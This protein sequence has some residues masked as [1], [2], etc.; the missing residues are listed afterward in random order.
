MAIN[1]TRLGQS[2]AFA[3]GIRAAAGELIVLI[4]ADLQNDPDDLPVL[5]GRLRSSGADMVQGDRRT[6]RADGLVR[7]VSSAAGRLARRWL[8]GD[9]I[10]DTGCSLRIL[11]REV[12][13]RLPL[14]Y[15][16]MHRFIPITCRQLGYTV[17][18]H[19]V[20]HRP[21]QAGDSKYGILNR[22]IPGL[23][24]CFAVRWMHKR[25]RPIEYEELA[26]G[27]KPKAAGKE[28]SS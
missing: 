17:V 4:D 25:R 5:L 6:A 13:L 15:R 26:A 22:A 24:D 1:R 19:P 12:A 3:A 20:R 9:T 7:R 27:D 18:E 11:S 14:E 23:I 21:R 10:N 16:G 8:L 2:A 28:A